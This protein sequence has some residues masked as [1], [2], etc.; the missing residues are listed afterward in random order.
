MVFWPIMCIVCVPV[1]IAGIGV[2]V[3]AGRWERIDHPD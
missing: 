2:L 1:A 3:L